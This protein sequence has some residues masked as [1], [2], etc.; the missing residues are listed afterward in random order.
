[1]RIIHKVLRTSVVVLGALALAACASSHGHHHHHDH[2]HDHHHGHDHHHDHHHGTTDGRLL[3]GTTTGTVAILDAHDGDVE[4]VFANALPEGLI[5]VYS[6]LSGEIGYA[7]HRDASRVLIID[8]GQFLVEHD[9]HEDLVFGEIRIIDEIRAGER[10]THFTT[11]VGRSGFYNDGSGNITVIREHHVARHVPDHHHHD[12]HH[13]DDHHHHDAVLLVPARVDHGAPI[14]LQ[15]HLLVGYV[16]E[17]VLEVLDY[18]GTVLQ[19]FP[20]IQRA[21]GQAR[22]GRFSA[23]GTIP[24]VLLVTQSGSTFDAHLVPNPADT[25]EGAR[26][27]HLHAH[28]RLDHF[29]GN[30][31]NGLVLVNPIERTS[32]FVPLPT[33]PWRFEID[34]SGHYVVV[35]GDD[36]SLHVLDAETL[37]VRSSTPVVQPRNPDAPAGTPLPGLAVGRRIA[38]VSDPAGNRILE[39]HLDDGD[40]EAEH[41]PDLDGTITSIAIMV[42][43]GIIH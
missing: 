22:V 43:D 14:L 37:A 12:D 33:R 9:G 39:V 35:L 41:R 23:F 28:P 30:L 19:S 7:V 36:G 27:G 5:A 2:D 16:G 17:T 18:E 26:T 4:A 32:R 3:I 1:M 29:V 21:H 20:D 24:G 40:I 6:N 10:P 38:W 15:N 25:P 8:S 34:R 11:T 31:G 13:H 42:T